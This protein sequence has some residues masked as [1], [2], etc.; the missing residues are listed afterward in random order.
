MCCFFFCWFYFCS[1]SSLLSMNEVNIKH[2]F[3]DFQK[4]KSYRFFGR[5]RTFYPLCR[6][7]M[8]QMKN[9]VRLLFDRSFQVRDVSYWITE[10]IGQTGVSFHFLPQ[11]QIPSSSCPSNFWLFF[12]FYVKYR[13]ILM[14][15]GLIW[16][17]ILWW[18]QKFLGSKVQSKAAR[19]QKRNLSVMKFL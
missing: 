11:K 18:A 3:S 19:A 6:H 1:V 13:A 8:A 2:W 4:K 14:F 17:K 12:H 7:F 15:L 5:I 16:C 10:G 9:F